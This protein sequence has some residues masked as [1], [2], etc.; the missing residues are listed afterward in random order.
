MMTA[1]DDGGGQRWVR[2]EYQLILAALKIN[3]A[4]ESSQRTS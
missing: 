2:F 4:L 1:R 3:E